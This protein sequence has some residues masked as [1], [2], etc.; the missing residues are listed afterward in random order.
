MSKESLP[1]L[2]SRVWTLLDSDERR[3]FLRLQGL[4]LLM[5]ISTLLG[6]AAIMPFLGIVADPG[7]LE[8]SAWLVRVHAWLGFT[9]HATFVTFLGVAFVAL[10]CVA[11]VLNLAGNAAIRRF[12]Y[13]T[14]ARLQG[15]LFAEYL[16]RNSL[17]HAQH[18]GAVLATRVVHHV[19]ALA[20]GILQ[21][22]LVFV[23]SALTC[24][25]IFTCVLVVS[26]AAALGAALAFGGS[27]AVIY[28]A[29]RGRLLENG[30]T[31]SRRWKERA[32]VLAES[33]GAIKEILVTGQQAH[34]SATLARE[35]VAIA[36]TAADTLSLAQLPR[37]L[38]ECIAAAGLVAAAIGLGGTAGG[39]WLAEISFLALA[40]YRLLPALQLAFAAAVHIGANRASFENIEADLRTALA[41]QAGGGAP[42]ATAMREMTQ[43]WRGRPRTMIALSGVSFRYSPHLPP[44]LQDVT[45]A[46]PA[47]ARV[48]FSGPN[49]S[50]KSTLADVIAGLLEPQ[51]GAIA[52]D[53]EPLDERTRSAW[54]ATIA[55]VPQN[56]FLQNASVA[57]NIAFGTARDAIDEER[58]RTAAGYAQLTDFI[59]SL[60]RGFDEPLG[61][62]GVRLSGG[63]R[64]LIGIARALYR[65]ASLLLLDEATSALDAD[66]ERRVIA[67][68]RAAGPRTAIV[69]AHRAAALRE[70]EYVCEFDRGAV[71]LRSS[72]TTRATLPLAEPNA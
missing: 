32:R 16:R 27:Y 54:Q 58:M 59:A 29:V 5:A 37:N 22:A 67:A 34:F 28:R 31:Q 47:G 8:R 30:R 48:A 71:T 72:A 41:R 44:A 33:F 7:L 9:S 57:E 6:L 61:E 69:I 56:T 13:G 43:A 39:R 45:L 42:A 24:L 64:Q 26:P 14:A 1:K 60:P 19:D 52:I 10:V 23:T 12:A 70:C 53:G 49:G 3:R 66:N 4:S 65:D 63:Q 38:I 21:N 15:A 62:R 40:A 55:Y 68:L 17:F 20:V 51:A 35:N 18:D 36:R 25:F 46:I 2:L 50:G 11:N